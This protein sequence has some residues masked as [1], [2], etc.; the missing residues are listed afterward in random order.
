MSLFK[1]GLLLIFEVRT[2]Y[3]ILLARIRRTK[4]RGFFF[5]PQENDLQTRPVISCKQTR[6]LRL[7]F[8]WLWVLKKKKRQK[9]DR[10]SR[11]CRECSRSCK[12]CTWMSQI[13]ST[14][15][16]PGFIKHWTCERLWCSAMDKFARDRCDCSLHKAFLRLWNQFHL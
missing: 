16:P 12:K 6:M 9:K 1:F 11:A 14:P 7:S 8:T 10:N 3:S 5:F 2:N 15:T 13:Y 4:W